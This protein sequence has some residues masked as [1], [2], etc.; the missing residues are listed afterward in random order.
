MTTPTK[1]PPRSAEARARAALE[2]RFGRPFSE[3]EWRLYRSRLIAFA[4]VVQE[5]SGRS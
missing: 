3:E 4:Q 2:E 1:V 5:W